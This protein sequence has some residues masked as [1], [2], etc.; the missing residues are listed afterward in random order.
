MNRYLIYMRIKVIHMLSVACP[1]VQ[2]R[3]GVKGRCFICAPRTHRS[4]PVS[5]WRDKCGR[6]LSLVVGTDGDPQLCQPSWKDM[7][8]DVMW[9]GHTA[10]PKPRITRQYVPQ[11]PQAATEITK[12]FPVSAERATPRWRLYPYSPGCL[13]CYAGHSAPSTRKPAK[14]RPVHDS[15]ADSGD[16]ESTGV[17]EHHNP[18]SMDTAA[19]DPIASF[20][21]HFRHDS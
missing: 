15:P 11:A 19:A 14:S 12:F 3:K 10:F 8:D 2:V 18:H 5:R 17:S 20:S 4:L 7:C 16:E 13:R 21:T 9:L 1:S 6:D